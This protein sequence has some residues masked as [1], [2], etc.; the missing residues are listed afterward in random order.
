MPDLP[1]TEG[2]VP[3]TQAPAS[4]TPTDAQPGTGQ[5]GGSGP[6]AAQLAQFDESI[7]PQVDA[8]LRSTV[9]PYV[10]QKEQ[11]AAQYRSRAQL[12]DDLESAPAET[13]LQIT[14]ELFGDEAVDQVIALLAP[15]E[16]SSLPDVDTST[17]TRDPEVEAMLAEHKA[18]KQREAYD[19]EMSRVKAAHA[20]DPIPV[21]E[22]LMHPFVQAAEGDFERAYEGY[23]QY[24]E[25]FRSQFAPSQEPATPP[26]PPAT[27][28]SDTNSTTAPP[29]Q[30]SYTSIDAALDDF[31]DEQRASAPPV[32]GGV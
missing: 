1:G 30:K 28:G 4:D 29:T 26:G 18:A 7:R 25:Q 13:Y 6:W 27:L 9:Q 22:D 32:V 21:V 15:D 8:F 3:A 20:N 11:E 23:S 16:D 17:P 12:F 31:F 14:Q 24:Y 2:Q 19:A 10:T 5:G